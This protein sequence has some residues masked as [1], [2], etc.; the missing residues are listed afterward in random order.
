MPLVG[1]R[2][3]FQKLYREY[4]KTYSSAASVVFMRGFIGR[5]CGAAVM[6]KGR[7]YFYR[8]R[9]EKAEWRGVSKGKPLMTGAFLGS[10]S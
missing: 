8:R 7:G 6:N 4:G 5:V 9:K 2:E 3:V 10:G 1:G